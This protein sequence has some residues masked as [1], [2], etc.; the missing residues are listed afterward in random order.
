M[1]GAPSIRPEKIEELIARAGDYKFD[2]R[3]PGAFDGI[4]LMSE[5]TKALEA[6]KA[7]NDGLKAKIKELETTRIND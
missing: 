3:K 2:V 4:A 7:E 1:T 5:L 6:F